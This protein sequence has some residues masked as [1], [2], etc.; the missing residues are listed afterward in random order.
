MLQ[1]N[2]IMFTYRSGA[3]LPLKHLLGKEYIEKWY[4]I[5]MI[6]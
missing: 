2:A 1:E 6:P 4:D 5:E 3:E